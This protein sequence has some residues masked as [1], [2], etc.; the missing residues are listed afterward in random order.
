MELEEPPDDASV[1]P[2]RE[3]S[4]SRPRYSREATRDNVASTVKRGKSKRG[5]TQGADPSDGPGERLGSTARAALRAQDEQGGDGRAAVL[6][7]DRV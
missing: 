1:Q 2:D 5:L 6:T 3:D 4:A 7:L